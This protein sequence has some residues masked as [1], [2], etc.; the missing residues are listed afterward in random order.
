MGKS[1][2]KEKKAV[3][4]KKLGWDM[5]VN[6]P[7]KKK[8][9]VSHGIIIVS[10]FLLTIMLLG[11]MKGIES[12]VERMY[13]GPVT[14]AS[15]VGDFRYALADIPRAIN[16]ARAEVNMIKADTKAIAA[17]AKEDIAADW[18][19]I[20][21]AYDIL[22]DTLLSEESKKKLETIHTRMTEIETGL[23]EFITMLEEARIGAA[24]IFYDEQL[25]PAIDGIRAEV[26][27]L[28][29]EIYAVSKE[30]TIKA[31]RIS[32]ILIIVGVLILAGVTA[33]AVIITKR[34]IKMI[35]EPLSEVTAAAGKMRQ[36]DMGAYTEIKHQ[37][38]DELGVL[39]E[40]MRGTM[41][42]LEDYIKEISD[43]L[44]RMAQGDLTKNFNEI[45]D[46]L[47]DF[48]SIKESFVY[49]LKEFNKTLSNINMVSEQVDRGSDEIATAANELAASTE[50]QASAVEELTA[51]IN[52]VTSMALDNA[53]GAEGAY[54]SVL[55]SVRNAEEKRRQ[56]EELQAE[57]QRIK[58]ISDEIANII[59]TIEEIADQTSLLSLNASI[60]AAR[61][62]EAGR[63][64]AV[65]ADQIGKLATDSA[66][67][68]VSTKALI[69]KTVAEIDKGNKI[70]EATAEAFDSIINEMTGFAGAAQGSKETAESQAE[71]LKQVEEGVNEVAAVTQ[72]NAASA[73]ES[74][75]TSEELA[76]RAAELSEQVN[77]FKL[78]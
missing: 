51:T 60:E 1:D 55:A 73:E 37:S 30:Y 22:Q 4:T 8:L 44:A 7:I 33:S 64:F 50:E 15:Y 40:S 67:A 10:T 58:E 17:E 41:M 61:A 35:A 53:K 12:Y 76:A 29:Q 19:L 6:A 74:L 27:A 21:Q 65:V 70:T 38:Q 9:T 49:I 43:I 32:L 25:K 63:G 45:T 48:A 75:A 46:F 16:Y 52:T 69:E 11:A 62:G 68:A 47:G 34:I 14:N 59:T 56:V 28:D 36:G 66:Q 39:A 13:Y 57:M 42:T 2:K 5:L 24:G 3:K 20:E 77:K 31:S 71:I 23:A 26:E 78:H 72:E 54:N 18:E